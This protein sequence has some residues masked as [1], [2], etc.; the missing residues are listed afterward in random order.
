MPGPSKG[1][2]KAAKAGRPTVELPTSPPVTEDAAWLVSSSLS[3]A[4]L[5]LVSRKWGLKV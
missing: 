1:D 3:G 5:D 2:S 4:H